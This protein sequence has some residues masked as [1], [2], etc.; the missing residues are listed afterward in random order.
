[1]HFYDMLFQKIKTHLY[2]SKEQSNPGSCDP[3]VEI[4]LEFLLLLWIGACNLQINNI[5]NVENPCNLVQKTH[6]HK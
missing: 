2:S 1:M 5:L 6:Q 4:G 3:F